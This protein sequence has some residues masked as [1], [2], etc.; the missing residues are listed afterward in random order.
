MPIRVAPLV[1]SEAERVILGG[2]GAV[3]N[4]EVGLGAAGADRAVGI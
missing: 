1:I 3:L 4:V 2:L